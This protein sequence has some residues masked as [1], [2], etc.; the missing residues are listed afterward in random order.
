MLTQSYKIFTAFL[1]NNLL[2]VWFICNQRYQVPLF[3]YINWYGDVYILAVGRKVLGDMKYLIMSVKRAE[4][5][6]GIWAEDNW[7]MKRMN[8]LNTMVY[9]R[10][11]FKGN[12]RFGSLI[13]S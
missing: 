4:E 12:T 11:V 13:W 3:R 2:Q 8:S 7:D 6:V 1:L 5:S 9:E 10:F